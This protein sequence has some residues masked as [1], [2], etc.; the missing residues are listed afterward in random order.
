MPTVTAW[1][2]RSY[3][4]HMPL[5]VIERTFAE[6]LDLT[7]EDVRLIDEIN[8]DEGVRWLFS[9]L[10]ADRRR[11]YCLYEAPSPE[12]IVAAARRANVPA[13]AVVEVGAGT[14]GFAGRLEDWAKSAHQA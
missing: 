14:P 10:S 7:S 2:R 12:A 11:T 6:D 3:D 9:F 4:G 13:D 5:Y 8:V 1:W